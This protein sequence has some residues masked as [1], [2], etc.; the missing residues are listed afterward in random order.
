MIYTETLG[1]E[2]T[3]LP[4]E[5]MVVVPPEL[6]DMAHVYNRRAVPL[7]SVK[8]YSEGRGANTSA[9]VEINVLE[10]LDEAFLERLR[11]DERVILVVAGEPDYGYFRKVFRELREGNVTEPG[12][13][14]DMFA[15]E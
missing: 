5:T 15:G 8:E 2:L 10:E 11:K 12:G 4:S 7:L 13:F 9:L 3:K 14:A 6:L 1:P